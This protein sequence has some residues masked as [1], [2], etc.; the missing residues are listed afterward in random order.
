MLLQPAVNIS[1]LPWCSCSP[2]KVSVF[3]VYWTLSN[4]L[5]LFQCQHNLS[6]GSILA[7]T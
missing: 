4:S 7:V 2:N 6:L 3:D 5:P 1:W